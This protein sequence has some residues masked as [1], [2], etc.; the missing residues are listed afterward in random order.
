M[1]TNKKVGFTLVELIVVI[2]IL[3][4]LWAIAFVALTSY[5]ADSRNSKRVS[6]LSSI[7]SAI[8]VKIGEGVPLYSSVIPVVSKQVIWL[9]IAWTW[10]T[11]WDYTAGYVKYSTLGMNEKEF[12]DPKWNE[13]NIW[14]TYKNYGRYEVSA[15]MEEAWSDRV[16][17]V[18]W[19]YFPRKTEVL[20]IELLLLLL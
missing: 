4:I 3:A 19:T 6:D 14:I 11:E 16:A 18:E 12:R 1:K 2:T 20:L 15:T 7:Q 9:S 5:T 13:Y 8:I 10:T 17:K